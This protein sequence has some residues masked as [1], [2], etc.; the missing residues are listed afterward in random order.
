M[1]VRVRCQVRIPGVGTVDFLVEEWLIVEGD[2]FEFHSDREAYRTDRRRGDRATIGNYGQLRF[3][4]EDT[5][6]LHEERVVAEVQRAL[7]L[8]RV[9][10]ATEK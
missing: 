6:P 1:G 3:T 9:D 5:A 2:G 10:Q 7:T 8:R 4:S